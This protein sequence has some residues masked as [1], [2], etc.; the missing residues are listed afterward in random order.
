M[1]IVNMT[2]LGL[3]LGTVMPLYVVAFQNVLPHR[4]MGL[5]TTM[6]PFSQTLGGSFGLAIYGSVMNSR[7]VTAFT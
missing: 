6:I 7:F 1:A 4:V 2:L 5:A 3:G